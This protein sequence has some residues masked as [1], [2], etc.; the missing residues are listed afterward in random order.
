MVRNTYLA[1]MIT[2]ELRLSEDISS[3][4]AAAS[5]NKRKDI[6]GERLLP[7]VKKIKIKELAEALDSYLSPTLKKLTNSKPLTHL[8]RN[9]HLAKMITNESRLSEDISSLLATASPNKRKDILEERLLSL[10]KKIKIKE[11]AEALDSYLSPTLKKPSNSRAI[12]T[13]NGSMFHGKTLYV[14]KTQSKEERK[15]KYLQQV[16]A[17]QGMLGPPSDLLFYWI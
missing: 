14:A 11:S 1:K 10:V 15:K 7:L 9:T 16:Y 6:L 4:T 13:L 17:R 2:T 5:P 8:M 3:L 12:N